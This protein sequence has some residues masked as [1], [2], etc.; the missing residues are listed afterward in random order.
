MVQLNKAYK[1]IQEMGAEVLAIHVECSEA[2]TK[3]TRE[4][5]GITY[6]LANDDR[7]GVV[8]KYGPTSTYLIDSWGI[9]RARWLDA[10]H[11]RVDHRG[12]ME[13]L[14]KLGPPSR[15]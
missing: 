13:A 11:S 14:S 9:V 2:G 6:P 7:L 5:Q 3:S 15:P 4:K 1:Q 8:D 12:I 10:V